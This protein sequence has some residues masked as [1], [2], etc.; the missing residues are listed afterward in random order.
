M[1]KW[2]GYLLLIVDCLLAAA[3]LVWPEYRWGQGRRSY[4]NFDNSLTLAS[5]LVSVQLAAVAILA[6]VTFHRER[7]FSKKEEDSHSAPSWGWLGGGLVALVISFL[8]AT[9]LHTRL[10]IFGYPTPDLY[11]Q[12]ILFPLWSGLLAL[13]GWFVCH[14]LRQTP[15]ALKYALGGL[16]AWGFVLGITIFDLASFS[17]PPT[18]ETVV[19]FM[20]G[21]AYLVGT[22]LLLIGLGTHVLRDNTAE[23]PISDLDTIPSDASF[24]T[25]SRRFWI[26]LGVGGTTGILIFLQ[27]I[28]FQLL[29]IF[30]NYLTANSVISIALLGLAVGGLVGYFTAGRAPLATMIAASLFLS[31]SI[32]IALGVPVSLM[33]TPLLASLLLMLP[34]ACGSTVI[35][36]ALARAHSHVVYFIDLLGAA[37]GALL[38]GP[39]L[40]HFRE[41]SSLLFLSAF[42]LFVTGCF[43]VAHPARRLRGWL[44]VP[45]LGSGI[46]VATIGLLNLE[47]DWLNV[48]RAK[49][50]KEYPSA[51]VLFSQSSLVGRYDIVRRRPH[52]KTL[53][54]YENGHNIDTI[55][56]K[57][58]SAYEID[59]RVPH[60]LMEDPTILIIGVSGD[61]ITK[62]ARSMSNNVYGVEIN[63]AVL[64][65]QTK[66]LL[67]YNANSYQDI[68]VALMDG[69]SFINQSTQRF[70]MITLMNT[71]AARGK[72]S[73]AAASPEF[74]HTHEAITAYLDRLTDRGIVIWEEPTGRPRSEPHIWKLLV[75]ARQALLDYGYPN[76]EQHFF[77]FQWKTG[78]CNYFQL[79]MKKTP[80]TPEDIQNLKQWVTDVDNRK[81]IEAQLG[82]RVGPITTKTTLLHVP[83]EGFASNYARILRGEV[84]TDFL[85]AHN[86]SVITDD[87]PFL[88][89]VDPRRLKLKA[90]YS[91]T[92]WLTL[93]LAPA[94]LFCVMRSRDSVSVTLPYIL[95][96]G[97]TGIGYFLIEALLIQR[98]ALF[99]GSPVVAF[100]TILC[101]LLVF[102]GLGSLWSGRLKQRGLYAAIGILLVLLLF[103]LSWLPAIFGFGAQ[104][105]LAGKVILAQLSLAPLAFFM[106]VPFPFVLRVAKEHFP[107]ATT[108]L[109]FAINAALSALAVP[110]ALNLS[111]VWGFQAVFYVGIVIY[112]AVGLAFIAMHTPRLRLLTNVGVTCLLGIL[113]FAPWLET[114][115][116]FSEAA[117]EPIYDVYGVSYGRS[118]FREDRIFADG[119]SRTRLPFD[120]LF[121]VIK[122]HD[123]TILVDTGF[124]DPALAEKWSLKRFVQPTDRLTQLNISP[125]DVTDVILTHAHWDHMGGLAAY[126]NARVWLQKQEYE[127][128]VST[129]SQATPRA[130]G[131]RWED[132]QLLLQAEQDGRLNLV[133][134]EATLMPGITMTLGGAHTLGSQYVNVSTFDGPVILAGDTTYLYE[135]NQWH[136]PIGTAVDH[137]AN[138]ATIQAMH[139]QAASPFMII[140]GHDP[141]V[142]KWFPKVSKGIVHI[143]ALPH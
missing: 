133:E 42:S 81:E 117:P 6:F 116:A 41:E 46:I 132:I 126:K 89:D 34:F 119:S 91:D 14:Q 53:S 101:T 86:L 114:Q 30:G 67:P 134:G 118:Y 128:A 83:G 88:F 58:V 19:P 47:H 49:K 109:L 24:P 110:L 127:H 12:L 123:R 97:L 64:R 107:E 102:S 96:V 54:T 138:L 122:G 1:F 20:R 87:R 15:T 93:L 40:S 94:L 48:M 32:L 141:K 75:T 62:T 111:P 35:T 8:E 56:N 68:D 38:I 18:W 70:D 51:R 50:L 59:P 92:L 10:D 26:L 13:C 82:R 142:R 43:I 61:A 129:V 4:F 84:S 77:I 36:V 28:L 143:T 100:T 76:P 9:R 99:L 44:L 125:L 66:E 79:L 31:V 104:L 106:G 90:T 39:A 17:L 131:M 69:R 103:H 25:D 130:R 115:P 45:T 112:L 140:P 3:H 120:W 29:T 98:Y 16:L 55:R 113:I 105:P 136:R 23:A 124:S 80:L 135:N 85:R 139:R 74:L 33:K 73:G 121:W 21:F 60:T 2:C 57:P 22:T 52:H 27:I 63:P 5:W 108:T 11:Q 78:C 72:T 65:L 7:V 95:V 137:A 71:H 37:C